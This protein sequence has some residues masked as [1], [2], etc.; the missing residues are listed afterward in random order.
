MDHDSKFHRQSTCHIC[1]G[2]NPRPSISPPPPPK[3]TP[4]N[5]ESKTHNINIAAKK[6]PRRAAS[7]PNVRA[8]IPVN[9]ADELEPLGENGADEYRRVPDGLELE[10]LE[11]ATV[12]VGNGGIAVER[13]VVEEAGRLL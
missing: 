4:L 8:A 13:A 7:G 10:E 3:K 5:P 2:I 11:S 12:V 6:A 9:G 1:H